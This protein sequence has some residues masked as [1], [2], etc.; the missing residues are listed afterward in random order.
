MSQVVSSLVGKKVELQVDRWMVRFCEEDL[1]RS[2]G[3]GSEFI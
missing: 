1:H 3:V 2:G